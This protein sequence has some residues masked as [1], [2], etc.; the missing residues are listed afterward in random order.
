MVFLLSIIFSSVDMNTEE[1]SKFESIYYRYKNA[2]YYQVLTIVN[3]ENDAEDVLQEAFIKIAKNLKSINDIKSKE[4]ISFLFVITKNTAYDYIRKTSKIIELPITETE[5]N[6]DES[7]LE[8]LISNIEYQEI[9]YTI[10]NIPSPYNEV[11]YLHYV[12]DYSIKKT[13]ALLG[14]K[15]ATVKMQLVR[16]KK[17]LI[18]KLSEVLY[19]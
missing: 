12:K 4:T 2:L 17:I 14:K 19:G 7:A 8:N 16:G 13:A 6:T 3:N 10:T 18:D 5:N 11:L 9:V 1:K 15:K